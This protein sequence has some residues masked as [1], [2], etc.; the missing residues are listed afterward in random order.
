MATCKC[1]ACIEQCMSIKL[2]VRCKCGCDDEVKV[3]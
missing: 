2:K 1:R 3:L